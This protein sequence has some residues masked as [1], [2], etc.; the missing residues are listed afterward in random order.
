MSNDLKRN[1]YDEVN[2][3]L[4]K[5]IGMT[6]EEVYY[7]RRIIFGISDKKEDVLEK[8]KYGIDLRM[9]SIQN[10][11]KRQRRPRT[12]KKIMTD[13]H[14]ECTQDRVRFRE[15]VVKKLEQ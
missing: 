14:R 15:G 5:K 7:V 12:L 3:A 9:T 2:R 8:I 11:N 10:F 6:G 1:Y 13:F 4:G